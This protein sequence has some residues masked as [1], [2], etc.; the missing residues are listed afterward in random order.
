VP[1]PWG[2]SGFPKSARFGVDARMSTTARVEEIDG[3]YGP[4]AIGERAIQ[5]L[6]ASGEVRGPMLA[7]SGASVEIVHP[8][9][10]NRGAG[11][12]FLGAELRV[13]GRRQR[14]DVE[15]HLRSAD[16][17]GHGHDRDPRYDG[18]I[19][20]AVLLPG[21]QDVLTSAGRRP[22]TA[23]LLPYLPR[24]LEDLAE[25]DALLELR[26]RAG[27]VARRVRAA[28]PDL[29]PGLRRRALERF[30]NKTKHARA[31]VKEAGWDAA[32]H[33]L[34]VEALGLGGNRAPMSELARAYS[35]E[36]MLIVGIDAMYMEKCGRWRLRG[37]RPA[38]HPHRRLAQYLELNRR[39]PDWRARLRDWAETLPCSPLPSARR[40]LVDE[41]FACLLPAGRADTLCVNALLPLL[42]D[43]RHTHDRSWLD[44]P[45]GNHPDDL[46]EARALLGFAGACRNWEVQGILD[47]LR[48]APAAAERDPPMSE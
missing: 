8:G 19:L 47:V 4:F 2:F 13:D 40:R 30:R 7:S 44:W 25:E 29:A 38:G 10:W 37:L 35:P 41:V 32:C 21:A 27:E 34:F 45:P 6:W 26:G 39:R 48:R 3:P 28:E 9:D 43:A 31:R 16:W 22:E 18:V 5:R 24:D 12:D 33:E 36:Q 20:H 17:R 1:F 14:G 42:Q 11:P 15:I 46:H 23:V